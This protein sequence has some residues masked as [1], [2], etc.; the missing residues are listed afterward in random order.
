MQDAK[1]K[2]S[3]LL[4]MNGKEEL[5]AFQNQ[6]DN[7]VKSTVYGKKIYDNFES[8]IVNTESFVKHIN[9]QVDSVRGKLGSLLDSI[10]EYRTE[11]NLRIQEEAQICSQNVYYSRLMQS[12]LIILIIIKVF[13]NLIEFKM[14]LI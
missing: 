2:L 1:L 13:L 3:E 14:V 6:I 12:K 7:S 5:K 11:M 4:G 10:K 8:K 9:N